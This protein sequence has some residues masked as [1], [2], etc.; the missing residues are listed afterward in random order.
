MVRKQDN[1]SWCEVLAFDPGGTTG[2]SVMCIRPKDL[3]SQ[4]EI[5]RKL[6]THFASGQIVGG[7]HEQV[8]QCV[9]LVD[10]WPHAAVVSE[11]FHQRI[12]NTGLETD[13][14]YSPVRI[15]A[16]LKWWLATEDRYLFKQSPSDAKKAW[17]DER[18]EEVKLDPEGGHA[19]RHARDGVRH[20]ALFLNRARAQKGLRHTA[21]PQFFN[22][23]GSL[24]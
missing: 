16:T 7:E 4:R 13:P 14:A 20:A 18:L 2:W 9:E 12:R 17:D 3:V 23:D 11:S 19:N 8:D 22:K 24:I 15:N 1:N 21:W 10:I 6:L 5:T